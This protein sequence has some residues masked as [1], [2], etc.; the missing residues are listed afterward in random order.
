MQQL[1][2]FMGNDLQPGKLYTYTYS[3]KSGGYTQILLMFKT[4]VKS[5]ATFEC[6]TSHFNDDPLSISYI[7][8]TNCYLTSK[9]LIRLT[10]DMLPSYI[11]KAISDWLYLYTQDNQ[12]DFS[13][14]WWPNT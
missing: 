14:E 1:K 3:Y 11:N 10:P 9:A 6:I 4:H 8:N 13:N 5:R 7:R 2:D 12:H